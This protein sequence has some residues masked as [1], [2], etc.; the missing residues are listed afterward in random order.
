[1]QSVKNHVCLPSIIVYFYQR[2]GAFLGDNEKQ[3]NSYYFFRCNSDLGCI[4]T[5]S[6]ALSIEEN[7]QKMII[8][9]LLS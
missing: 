2:P 4:P 3:D 8:I 5:Q 1:M 9:V 6:N 7:I